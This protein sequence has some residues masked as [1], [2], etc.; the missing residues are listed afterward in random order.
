MTSPG[1]AKASLCM[2]EDIPACFDVMSKSFG[3]DAPFVNAYFPAHATEAGRTQ[4]ISRLLE[5]KHSSPESVFLKAVIPND[6]EGQEQIAGMAVWTLMKEA[7]PAEL[8]DAEDVKSIWPDE[9][10]REFMTLLWREYVIPR[11]EAIKKG[12]D[13]GLWGKHVMCHFVFVGREK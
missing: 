9:T 4:G 8:E 12:G 6:H 11:S 10:E 3:T 5:W 2:D 13:T 1:K 7:P